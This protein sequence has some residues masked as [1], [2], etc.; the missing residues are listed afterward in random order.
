MDELI[1]KRAAIDA[2]WKALYEYEDKTEKQFQESKDLDVADWFQHRLFV[3]NMNDIDRQTILN[4]PSAQQEPEEFEWCT[5][6][7]EYDQERHCC[8]RWNRVIRETV[9]EVRKNAEPRWIPVEYEPPEFGKDVLISHKG[10]VSID[11]LT[12]SE[13]SAYFF[14]S[15]AGI[16]DI[17]A[18]QP[19]PQPYERSE[20]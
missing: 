13:G 12:Q 7:K 2:L 8:P 3:Q 5:D 16:A 18:W 11:W 20:E 17:D 10:T 9:E 1:S 14:M 19:L 6:C 4:L 15:G